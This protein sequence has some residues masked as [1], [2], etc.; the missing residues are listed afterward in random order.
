[1][2]DLNFETWISHRGLHSGLLPR[3][4][5]SGYKVTNLGKWVPSSK[6]FGNFE[7]VFNFFDKTEK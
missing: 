6:L 5:T 4:P 7:F 3:A 2:W 1:M